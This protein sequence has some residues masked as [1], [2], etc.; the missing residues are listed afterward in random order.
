VF[1]SLSSNYPQVEFYKDGDMIRISPKIFEALALGRKKSTIRTGVRIAIP[2]TRLVVST[3]DGRH[4]DKLV[5]SVI[6]KRLN[7]VTDKEAKLDGFRSTRELMYALR[8]FYRTIT[9][10]D[11]VTIINFLPMSTEKS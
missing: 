8:E 9:G 6:V 3:Q 5:D 1:G 10:S 2:G 11:V 7:D 4:V